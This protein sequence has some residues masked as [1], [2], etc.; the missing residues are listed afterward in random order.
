MNQNRVIAIAVAAALAVMALGY[1]GYQAFGSKSNLAASGDEDRSAIEQELTVA[2]PMGDMSLGNP[3]ASVRVYE[4]ASLTCSHCAEFNRDSFPSFKKDY[5]DTGKVYYT[6]RDFPFDPIATAAYM[7]AH[8][9]GPDRYFGFI[10]VLFSTQADWAFVQTPME[11]LKSIAKQGGFSEEKFDAC[12]NN[13][14]IFEHVKK[15]AERGAGT[16]GVRSTP[17]FFVNGEKIEGALPYSEFEPIL[18]KHLS[19]DD[20]AETD[21]P[22][23]AMTPVT[24]E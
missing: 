15:V 23:G 17:T 18:K 12:M 1:L 24:P 10:D 13:V 7:L 3:E 5:I 2:G 14:E 11:E 9:A 4:Y 19:G 21:T 22:S 6:L 16:F 8:C 20:T